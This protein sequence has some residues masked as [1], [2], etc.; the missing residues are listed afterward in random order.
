MQAAIS[1]LQIEL[2]SSPSSHE[3]VRAFQATRNLTETLCQSLKTEDYVVQSMPDCSPVKWHLAHTSWFFETFLLIPFAKNYEPFHPCFSVLFNSYY[4]SIGP[5]FERAKR[6]MLTRPTVEDVMEYR[7]YV[8]ESM[9]ALYGVSS[10][11]A[12]VLSRTAL[13]IHHEQQH[14]ELILMDVLNLFSQNLMKPAYHSQGIEY[15]GEAREMNWI[16]HG[17]GLYKI[18]HARRDFAFDHEGPEHQVFLPSFQL[19]DRLVTNA[20]YLRFIKEGGYERPEFW[21]SDGWAW[22]KQNQISKPLYWEKMGHKYYEFSLHGL[23][24]LSLSSPV[25]HV[26][27]YEA[28]AYARFAGLRLPTEAEWEV[29]AEALPVRGN[30]LDYGAYK[31]CPAQGDEPQFYGDIWQWTASAYLPYPGFKPASG[32]IGEYNGKFMSG[33]MVL[34]GG[35]FATPKTHIRSTYRNFFA[36]HTRWHFS[37]I[38][39]AKFTS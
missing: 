30:F 31:A 20:E 10:V 17:E 34:R 38:R 7:K 29:V 18:G 32:Q 9:L 22:R 35:S 2:N 37:G 13:G 6:E 3:L 12:E 27:F 8:T 36:P 25:S 4:E 28:D 5:S 39:L 33:Q 24:S 23:K 1:S 14:Q 11:C 21:L 19:A 26:S 15:I 16:S